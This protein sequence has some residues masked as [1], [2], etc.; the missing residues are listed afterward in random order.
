M[1]KLKMSDLTPSMLSEVKK[2]KTPQDV[3]DYFK[4]KHYDVSDL[5]A[6]KILDRVQDYEHEL[7]DDELDKVA[8]GC[9]APESGSCSRS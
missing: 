4:D 1:R 2:L 6:K 9:S 8:G 3:I 7:S 5:T